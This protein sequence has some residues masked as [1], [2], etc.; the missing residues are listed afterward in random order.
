MKLCFSKRLAQFLIAVEQKCAMPQ[1][2]HLINPTSISLHPA[3]PSSHIRT[4]NTLGYGRLDRIVRK[5]R[6]QQT[7]QAKKKKNRSSSRSIKRKKI[8][9]WGRAKGKVGVRRVFS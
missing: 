6:L 2:S 9:T 5:R 3:R 7:Q 4:G 1:S 8:E